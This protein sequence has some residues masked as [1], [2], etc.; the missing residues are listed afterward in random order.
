MAVRDVT[1]TQLAQ[2]LASV[3]AINELQKKRREEDELKMF[4]EQRK[5]VIIGSL[6]F[7]L[8]K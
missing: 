2:A 3:D 5:Q 6:L 1:H 4:I 7:H 8:K